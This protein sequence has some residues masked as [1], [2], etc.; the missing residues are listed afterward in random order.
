MPQQEDWLHRF[1][2]ANVPFPARDAYPLRS[3]KTVLLLLEV[4]PSLAHGM[5]CISFKQCKQHV[6]AH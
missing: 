2:I 1:C 4:C 6:A 5:D 3:F